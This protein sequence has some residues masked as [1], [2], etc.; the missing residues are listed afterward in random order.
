M[1]KILEWIKAHKVATIIIILGVFLFP[2]V[3]VH[4]AYK[5]NAIS[6]WFSSTWESGDLITYIAGFEA[7][8]GTV[9]LGVVAIKQNENA[10]KTNERMLQNEEA[11]DAFERQPSLMFLGQECEIS[12]L[13][14]YTASGNGVFQCHSIHFNKIPERECIL[15]LILQNTSKSFI[16]VKPLMLG[17]L[18]H[19]GKPLAFHCNMACVYGQS[20][21]LVSVAPG[22][23]FRIRVG[24][25]LE[26]FER[27]CTAVLELKLVLTNSLGE[28]RNERITFLMTK[29]NGTN[30]SITNIRYF[31]DEDFESE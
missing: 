19:T 2:L 23:L 28:I 16:V 25:S 17:S 5:I 31:Y 4:I 24:T 14:E 3:L 9:V 18:D 22:E 30:F 21:D 7:F 20:I 1:S 13:K 29:L 26:A 15:S 8:L 10:N 12:T 11:R 6:P 27:Y